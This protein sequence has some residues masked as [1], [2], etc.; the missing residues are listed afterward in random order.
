MALSQIRAPIIGISCAIGAFFS[1]PLLASETVQPDR[2]GLSSG[3]YTVNPG[4]YIVEVGVQSDFR[5]DGNQPNALA[6]PQLTV[7]G[8]ITDKLEW[9]VITNGAILSD[10]DTEPAV[11]SFSDVSVGGKYSLIEAGNWNLSALALV[12][13]PVGSKESTSDN[14]DPLVGLLWDA[15][16][17]EHVSAF[18][19]IQMSS[20]EAEEGRIHD[21]QIALGLNYL[22]SEKLGTFVELFATKPYGNEPS[23]ALVDAGI[24]YLLKDTIQLDVSAGVALNNDTDNFI[25]A[26]VAWLF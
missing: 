16:V 17:D 8:G 21:V 22:Y 6:I 26:G 1:L 7:R 11:W 13:L 12:S 20:F 10:A 18:A 19:N 9:D 3:T 15:N 4:R 2:P 25:G 14:V 5:R 23:T 24:T